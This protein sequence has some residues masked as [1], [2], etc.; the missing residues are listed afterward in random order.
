MNHPPARD[1]LDAMRALRMRI[2]D[3]RLTEV[4][5]A[6]GC[7]DDGHGDKADLG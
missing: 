7:D 4:I 1:L 2:R 5:A 3:Y 6:E